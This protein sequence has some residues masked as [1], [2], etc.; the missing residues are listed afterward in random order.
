MMSLSFW[1]LSRT[2]NSALQV[3][4]RLLGN[5]LI[6]ARFMALEPPADPGTWA[7][8]AHGV[9]S[10]AVSQVSRHKITAVKLN[11]FMSV[12]VNGDIISGAILARKTILRA[13]RTLTGHPLDLDG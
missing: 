6:M 10:N 7:M 2:R 12:R 1:A 13:L 8:A 4:A 3:K 5:N 9:N 11:R